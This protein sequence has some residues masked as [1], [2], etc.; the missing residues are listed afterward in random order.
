MTRAGNCSQVSEEAEPGIACEGEWPFVAR[1]EC[2]GHKDLYHGLNF[3]FVELSQIR[4]TGML[5]NEV[6]KHRRALLFDFFDTLKLGAIIIHGKVLRG[7]CD[8]SC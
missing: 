5:H 6:P 4:I 8:C 2:M 1:V 3:L 7:N